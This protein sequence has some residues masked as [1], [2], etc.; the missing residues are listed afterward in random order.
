M[1]FYML[2]IQFLAESANELQKAL[3]ILDKYCEDNSLVVNSN[4]T[5]VMIF[6]RGIIRN[7]P[8]FHFKNNELEVVKSY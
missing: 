2:M 6:S 1:F 3:D 7:D 5:K 8:Q 4:K